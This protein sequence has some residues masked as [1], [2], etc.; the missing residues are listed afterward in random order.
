VAVFAAPTHAIIDGYPYLPMAIIIAKDAFNRSHGLQTHAT[1]SCL[2][3][4]Q[5]S[6]QFKNVGMVPSTWLKE[7]IMAN[8]SKGCLHLVMMLGLASTYTANI[9]RRTIRQIVYDP[10][11]WENTPS[12]T[13]RNLM[14]DSQ[15][16]TMELAASGEVESGQALALGGQSTGPA[17]SPAKL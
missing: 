1:N 7:L 10:G 13:F 15:K 5:K 11:T 17:G 14:N 3:M 4:G 2:W 9:L 6:I 16:L 8:S 12:L